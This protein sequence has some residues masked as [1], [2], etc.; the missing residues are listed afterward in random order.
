MYEEKERREGSRSWNESY[1]YMPELLCGRLAMRCVL[2][3]VAVL[4]ATLGTFAIRA[5]VRTL[6]EPVHHQASLTFFSYAISRLF[7]KRK[8]LRGKGVGGESKSDYTFS[9]VVVCWEQNCIIDAHIHVK[10]WNIH[11]VTVSS[12]YGD[13]TRCFACS[14]TILMKVRQI[15][16]KSIDI[17]L[18]EC[19]T[20]STKCCVYSSFCFLLSCYMFFVP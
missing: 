17:C 4:T 14:Q 15:S 8:G 11:N 2:A 12:I 20:L 10:V 19:Q 16:A 6:A 1:W 13:L 3:Y 9:L 7:W 18:K 5:L